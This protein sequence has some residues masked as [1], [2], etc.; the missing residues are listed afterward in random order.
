[1]TH[2]EVTEYEPERLPRLIERAAAALAK[3]TTAAEILEARE[4]AAFVYNTAKQWARFAKAKQ[5]HDEIL[6]ACHRAMA[7]ALIIETQAQCRL[8][9][10]YDAAQQRGEAAMHSAG[11]PKIVSK[12]DDLSGPATSIELGIKRQQLSEARFIRDAETANPGV[13]RRTVQAKLSAG[14]APTRADVLRAARPPRPQP[15][16]QPSPPAY[17]KQVPPTTPPPKSP[18]RDSETSIYYCV[19]EVKRHV[20][21]YL[22]D[23]QP[24]QHWRLIA[25]LQAMLDGLDP[26]ER[27]STT[28]HEGRPTLEQLDREIEIDNA[29]AKAK[30]DG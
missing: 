29:R 10:E 8:A 14:E 1:M 16:E 13:V 22:S 28:I 2:Q 7:D 23:L 18:Q 5:A 12:P 17:A 15:P 27:K 4:T 11:R 24:E 25:E 26:V 9:D 19:L 20:L 21:E 3:A 30:K 6:T